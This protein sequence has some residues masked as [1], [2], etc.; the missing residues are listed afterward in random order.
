MRRERGLTVIIAYKVI[1]GGLWL[2]LAPALAAAVHLGLG[3][4][5]VGLAAELRHSTH[6]WSLE[7]A[8]WI[9][10]AATPR[11]LSAMV[12]ALLADGSASLVEAWALVRGRWWGPWLVVVTTS[13]L[14]PLE[15]VALIHHLHASRVLLLALNLAIVVYLARKALAERRLA[16]A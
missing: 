5:L 11:G 4:R 3:T 1:K 10:R 7:L 15:V 8:K 14:L 13:A 16:S 9:V 2:V 12:V 6:A